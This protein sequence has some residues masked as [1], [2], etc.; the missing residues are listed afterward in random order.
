MAETEE[1]AFP[2]LTDA[3]RALVTPLARPCEYADREVIFRAGQPD[4]DLYVV[5]SG[6]MEIRNPNDGDRLITVHEAGVR[7][8]GLL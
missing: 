5:E 4:I 8:V 2:L 1:I 6:G 7:S 3:E